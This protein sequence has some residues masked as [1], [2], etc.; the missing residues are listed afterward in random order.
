MKK[1]NYI[2]FLIIVLIIILFGCS[3]PDVEIKVGLY[4]P[5]E[6]FAYIKIE[7][8][9]NFRLTR[10]IAYDYEPTG[11]YAIEGDILRLYVNGDIGK[12]DISFKISGDTLIF[13]S[14]RLLEEIIPKEMEFEYIDEDLSR[15]EI[16][17]KY[18]KFDDNR[19]MEGI[20]F[21]IF[22]HGKDL[23]KEWGEPISEDYLDGGL[24]MEYENVG[25]N[26]SGYIAEDGQNVYGIINTIDSK[27]AYG[28]KA[29]MTIEKSREILGEPDARG[30]F[31]EMKDYGHG[32]V[33]PK[34]F[35][36]KG[37]FTLSIPY[38]E[39]TEEFYYLRLGRFREEPDIIGSGFLGLTQW[40][41]DKYEDYIVDFDDN[42]LM[43]CT[44]I[45][46]MK[47]YI[48]ALREKNYEAE[49]ELYTRREDYLGWDKEYHMAEIAKDG[50]RDFSEFS[51]AVNVELEYGDDQEYAVVSWEDKYLEEYDGFGNPFRYSFTLVRDIDEYGNGIWKVGFMPMQ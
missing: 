6:S 30:I 42:K 11:T 7:E 37:D 39:E 46:V 40:E 16:A 27:E 9:K 13:Q 20:E 3:K 26:T 28:V 12:D 43:S 32:K 35:Y 24:Y 19:F 25:F 51:N 41:L 22:D 10:G 8:D 14:G 23:V 17:L 34:D 18:F 1:S 49:W 5:N 48:H 31:D 4:L 36:Y 38:N 15:E 47:I 29:G 21:G 45:N 2:L 50:H 33:D 44:P